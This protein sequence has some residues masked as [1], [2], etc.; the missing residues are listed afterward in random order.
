[1]RT[2]CLAFLIM[3]VGIGIRSCVQRVVRYRYALEK[4]SLTYWLQ[5]GGHEAAAIR[6]SELLKRGH[7]QVRQILL[8]LARR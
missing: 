4:L 5:R 8:G 3:I 1:M 6:F 7:R 2:N